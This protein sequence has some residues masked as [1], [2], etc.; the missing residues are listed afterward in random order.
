MHSVDGHQL[1]RDKYF[2]ASDTDAQAAFAQALLRVFLTQDGSTTRLCEAIARDRVAIHLLEQAVV[3]QLPAQMG[4]ALPGSRFLRRLTAIE[5]KGQVMLDSISY[6]A[7]DALGADIVQELEAGVTP[8]GHLLARLWTRRSFRADD[9]EL[10]E[11]LWLKVGDPDAQASRSYTV[12]TP[13]GPCMI[14]GETFRRGI[15][16]LASPF[17]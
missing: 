11:E 8:I 6:I 2:R 3:Q 4:T 9:T 16:T 10:F 5:A 7:M 15:L 13:Q 1:Q 12:I 14:I 17:A